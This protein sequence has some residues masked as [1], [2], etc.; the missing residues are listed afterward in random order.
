MITSLQSISPSYMKVKF[1]DNLK[2]TFKSW[3]QNNINTLMGIFS[4]TDL[5]Y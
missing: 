2:H 1:T 3:F 5:F 4:F